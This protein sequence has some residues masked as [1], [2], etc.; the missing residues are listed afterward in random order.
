M[1]NVYLK[2]F[3]N[4]FSYKTL[5]FP[6]NTF[7][8]SYTLLDKYLCSAMKTRYLTIYT[9]VQV[10]CNQNVFLLFPLFQLKWWIFKTFK[11]LQ[12]KVSSLNPMLKQHVRRIMSKNHFLLHA[13][14][15]T[16]RY[17]HQHNTTCY[18]YVSKQ[19]HLVYVVFTTMK[20][21]K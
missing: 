2:P 7:G 13:K 16:T 4:D 1:H 12:I 10:F 19:I 3:Q 20:F 18:N 21:R 14:H 11:Y 9:K 15:F 17:I 8:E 5:W 6:Q